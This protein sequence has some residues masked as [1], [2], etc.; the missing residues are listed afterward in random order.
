MLAHFALSAPQP[1]SSARFRNTHA[2]GRA[3]CTHTQTH[4]RRKKRKQRDTLKHYTGVAYCLM[5]TQS[6][7]QSRVVRLSLS[8]CVSST[9][10][11]FLLLSAS[12]VCFRRSR[13]P[14][15]ALVNTPI[16]WTMFIPIKEGSV[17]CLSVRLSVRVR[18]LIC[19]IYTT[20]D[21]SCY[22][23]DCGESHGWIRAAV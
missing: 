8:L 3:R 10:L 19:L 14:S 12:S 9:R 2:L 13:A 4:T 7:T 5:Q 17:R 11:G 22:R 6:V 1:G 16:L 21:E 20:A 23:T 18:A 15:F